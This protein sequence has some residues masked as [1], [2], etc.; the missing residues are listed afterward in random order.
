ML[1]IVLRNG[2]RSFRTDH[3]GNIPNEALYFFDVAKKFRV[4][5][6]GRFLTRKNDRTK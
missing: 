3:F 6:L 4:P 1:D 5:F 2:G